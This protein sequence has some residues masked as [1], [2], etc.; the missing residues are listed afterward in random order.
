ML[1]NS[2][3]TPRTSRISYPSTSRAEGDGL[4]TIGKTVAKVDPAFKT[5]TPGSNYE[6]IEQEAEDMTAPDLEERTEEAPPG[7]HRPAPDGKPSC[8]V[9]NA[10]VLWKEE[11]LLHL[12]GSVTPNVRTIARNSS[13]CWLNRRKRTT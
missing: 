13:R 3:V 5:E 7:R 9:V 4:V 10:R 8:L 2:R 1:L 11:Y 12:G 6:L